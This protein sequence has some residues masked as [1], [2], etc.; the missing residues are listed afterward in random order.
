MFD[1]IEI[2]DAVRTLGPLYA[3]STSPEVSNNGNRYFGGPDPTE[4]RTKYPCKSIG[5]LEELPFGTEE[6]IVK[7]LIEEAVNTIATQTSIL[8]SPT[9]WIRRPDGLLGLGVD[10]M[11]F[12][13]IQELPLRAAR[14]LYVKNTGILVPKDIPLYRNA[15]LEGRNAPS[16]LYILDILVQP[17]G[18]QFILNQDIQF[19]AGPW[20][21]RV[22]PTSSHLISSPLVFTGILNETLQSIYDVG[23][24]VPMVGTRIKDV[25]YQEM[26]YFDFVNGKTGGSSWLP[27][28]E[29]GSYE[30]IKYI[31]P[32]QSQMRLFLQ[33][34]LQNVTSQTRPSLL[35][36]T[37]NQQV[38]IQ[39]G[40]QSIVV[41]C[42][43]AGG[44]SA[45]RNTV[46]S[47]GSYART[48]LTRSM[49]DGQFNLLNVIVGN[50]GGL[51]VSEINPGEE[52]NK[53]GLSS[54]GLFT[55]GGHFSAVYLLGNDFEREYLIVAGGGSSGGTKSDGL[56]E[57][58]RDSPP[59]KRTSYHGKP[60][61]TDLLRNAPDAY[62][63][64]GGSG[65][66][67]HGSAG[68]NGHGGLAGQSF[69][70]YAQNSFVSAS[71]PRNHS[72]WTSGIGI[73]SSL[74]DS[75]GP[76]LV[77]LEFV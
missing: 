5:L 33:P 41:H 50:P 4:G 62:S 69:V 66:P 44:S 70:K 60:T 7:S 39:S 13:P 42:F 19:S 18:L 58:L 43:G 37:S 14:S 47:H 36:C 71:H 77:V 26:K 3:T 2:F 31:W 54:D 48:I 53:G 51:P 24:N 56:P 67:K 68:S 55:S 45:S 74:L 61:S 32:I 23:Q 64:A 57:H 38:Q 15:I 30:Y 52:D 34:T 10:Y 8:N 11:E 22:L 73:G 17:E 49:F 12:E 1:S 72:H 65:Y 35:V 21:L 59:M 75:A 46:G 20:I 9:H 29:T 16:G 63:G 28:D 6:S 25:L 27:V 40:I 76:G